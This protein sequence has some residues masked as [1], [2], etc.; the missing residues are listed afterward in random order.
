MGKLGINILRFL[1]LVVFQVF[2]FKNI[3]YYNLAAPFP[4]IL[5]L[6]LLPFG[7]SNYI[8]YI[9]GFVTGL[10]ID[11]FYDTLGVH[12]AASVMLIF[13]RILF[14]RITI[15]MESHERYATPIIGEFSLRWFITYAGVGT[16][17]HHFVLF[18]L[19]AFSFQ[20]FGYTLIS[21]LLSSIFTLS[22]IMLYGLLFYQKKRR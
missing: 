9:I 3:G 14:F 10:T 20:Y 7:I 13:T 15:D 16:I 17:A 21:M 11:A 19:E 1:I 22:L 2:L 18:L 4:Y 8:L 5:I 6:L 12:A